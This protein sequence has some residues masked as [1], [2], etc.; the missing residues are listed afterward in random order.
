MSASALGIVPARAG[1]RR[2]P[3]KN[4]AR[5]L[6]RPLVAHTIA[7]ALEVEGLEVLVTSDSA[8][9][10]A[11]ARAAGAHRLVRRPDALATARA[12]SA[13]V[14]VHALGEA[15][16]RGCEHELIVLLQPTSPLR[17]AS[18]V[19]EALALFAER[20]SR[21]LVSVTAAPEVDP[22]AGP[23]AGSDAMAEPD[24]AAPGD[25]LELRAGG[26]LVQTGGGGIVAPVGGAAGAVGPEPRR[27]ILNGAIY[28]Q[29]RDRFLAAPGFVPRTGD[30][31]Y[32]MD[33]AFSVDIDTAADFARAEAARAA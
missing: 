19:R 13:D 1:S 32:F 15:R 6:G 14:V 33:P 28:L 21:P 20:G 30:T 26:V 12:S 3:G 17:T 25:G 2:L 27:V 16:E 18:H 22:D 9:I 23:D 4:V 5:F 7:S 8:E 10:L 24:G 29:R 31:G 11:L